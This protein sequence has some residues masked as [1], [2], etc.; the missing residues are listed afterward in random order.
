MKTQT[1]FKDQATAEVGDLLNVLLADEHVL[2][3]TTQD[4]HW[5]V[6]GPEFHR[7]HQQF[8]TQLEE[9]STWI[10]QIAKRVR[11]IGCGARGN[12][13]YLTKAPRLSAEPGIDLASDR[14]LSELLSLH[15][16]LIALLREDIDY[17]GRFGDAGT[18]H[19]LTDLMVAHENAAWMLRA[20]LGTRDAAVVR[21]QPLKA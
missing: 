14:M 8:E 7:L 4:Y 1:T 9:I 10:N 3:V 5:N 15:D 20:Q 2:Y 11:A 17:T 6:T 18:G 21:Y 12:W 19:L 13:A 16:G